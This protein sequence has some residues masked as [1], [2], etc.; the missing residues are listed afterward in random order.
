MKIF[1][2]I[3]FFLFGLQAMAS[4]YP[5]SDHYD[6]NKFR[7]PKGDHLL[8]LLDIFQWKWN[9]RPALWPKDVRNKEFPLVPLAENGRGVVTFINHA[10]FLI[11]LPGL[12]IITDPIYC[13]RASPIDFAG[14]KRVRLPGVPFEKL[15]RIDVVIIS[16]N[17]YD[18]LDV[19]A[20]KMID[21]KFHPLFL[22]PLGNRAFLLEKG[23]QIV[24]EL[25]WWQEFKVRENKFVLTP[26]EH[27]SARYFWDKNDSLWGGY[28]IATPQSKIFFA[29]DTGYGEHFLDIKSRLGTPDVA[30]LP[31]GAYE[32][33]DIMKAHHMNPS[34][35]LQASL[36]L[37]ATKSIGMHFGTFQLTD[38]GM[39]DPVK[40]LE[41]ALRK[42]AISSDV[43][44]TLR[45][46]ESY[47]F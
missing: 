11:Q 12:N 35:A 2:L 37:E 1:I 47:S 28:M 34:E 8:S 32:P 16:H 4:V 42:K 43:F 5:L 19:D 41:E 21:E 38:E 39:D 24:Q 17:H 20:L 29:G 9:A 18:H 40:K 45:E 6:G 15:P 30:L 44:T 25:D 10:T 7:N 14:P 13:D 33:R 27:W 26:A 46:S 22:V 23:I 31:I 3:F 36:D